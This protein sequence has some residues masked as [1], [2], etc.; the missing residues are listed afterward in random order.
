MNEELPTQMIASPKNEPAPQ[1]ANLQIF[2]N[3]H[4]LGQMIELAKLFSE[5]DLVPKD[6]K[7]KKGN[8]LVAIQMG[9]ELGLAPM[10]ALQNIAVINGRPCVW[11]DAMLAIVQASGKLEYHHE[12]TEGD[13]AYCKTKRRG[14]PTEYITTFSDADAKAA[15]LL[16]K[17]GPWTTNR[18]RMRQMRARAFNLRDQFADVLRGLNSGEEVSDYSDLSNPN[19]SNTVFADVL[20]GHTTGFDNPR[21]H[22]TH[23]HSDSISQPKRLSNQPVSEIYISDDERKRLYVAWK[24]VGLED[25]VVSQHLR[26]T[27]GLTTTKEIKKA[28]YQDIMQWIYSAGSKIPAENA[29]AATVSH[30]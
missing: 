21:P 29:S 26:E 7:D 2:T 1:S 28:V 23:I 19:T 24:T 16:G 12:W 20:R 25:D 22:S 11:G 8:T 30:E 13:T 10:Q 17:T 27:Y 6:Y 3:P 5:S 15:N 18:A 9:M 14:Y 4:L